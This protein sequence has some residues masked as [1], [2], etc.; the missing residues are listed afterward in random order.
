MDLEPDGTTIVVQRYADDTAG[1]R[2][3]GYAGRRRRERRDLIPRLRELFAR[4]LDV[5]V[6]TLDDVVVRTARF[7]HGPPSHL[8]TAAVD[9]RRRSS[10]RQGRISTCG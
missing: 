4:P 10:T 2:A 6:Q 1:V 5:F 9:A 7:R 8:L 3:P